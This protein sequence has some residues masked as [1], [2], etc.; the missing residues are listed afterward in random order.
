MNKPVA[1][2]SEKERLSTF[3]RIERMHPFQ[4]IIYLA[5]FGSGLIFL[6]FVIA[7]LLSQPDGLVFNRFY[8]PKAFIASSFAILIS[9]YTVSRLRL[10]YVEDNIR[11]L[12]IYTGATLILGLV[13]TFLQVLGWKELDD[14]GIK[15]NGLP[16]GSFLYII[17]GIHL[18]H[19]LGALI[20]AISLFLRVLK[21][22]VDPVD[23]LIFATNPFDQLKIRLFATYWHFMD[24]LWIILFFVFLLSF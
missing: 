8:I 4:T 9:S 18:V 3:E 15:F 20:F 24:A 1:K 5:M 21:I 19:L 13:F 16:S 10:F 12:L 23:T 11:Q 17:S 14:M 22:A 2:S 6:F 7:F